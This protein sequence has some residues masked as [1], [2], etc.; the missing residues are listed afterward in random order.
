MA[1]QR[2]LKK[3][4]ISIVAL[5][6]LVLAL[7]PPGGVA[8]ANHPLLA[9]LDVE[10]ELDSNTTLA[11]NNSHTVTATLRTPEL[12]PSPSC[13]GDPMNA[14]SGGGSGPVTIRFEILG[15]NDPLN[16]GDTPTTP[17][18]TCVIPDG[19]ASCQADYVGTLEGTDVI[20]GWI[21]HDGD[22]NT[23]EAD[24]TEE[25]EEDDEP[26]DDDEPDGTDVVEKIWKTILDCS[27]ETDVN[28]RRAAHTITC[29]VT[30]G[31]G[32][33][34][35]GVQVDAEATGASD[36]DGTGSRTSPDF[37][38]T[39]GGDGTCAFTHGPGGTGT[40]FGFGLTTYRAWIDQDGI[41]S[42]SEAD[43]TE[44]RDENAAPGTIAEP[45]QT[46]VV[47]KTWQSNVDCEP[48]TEENDAG[49][50][51][52]ITCTVSN[53][54]N[55][56]IGNEKI[57]VEATGANDPDDSNSPTTYD[58][59]CTTNVS[60]TCSFTHG[61]GGS[62]S[63]NSSGVTTYRAWVDID[64]DNTTFD[65]DATEGR[66]EIT[67]P[68]GRPEPDD[69]DVVEK[70]WASVPADGLDA[71]P[72]SARNL[73]ATDHT[74]TA[75]LYDL[76]GN[77]F[78]LDTTVKFEFFAGSVSDTDGNTPESPDKTCT[79]DSIFS[80]AV[81]YSQNVGAGTDLVCVWTNEDPAMLGDNSNG[82][83]NGEGL[84]DLDDDAGNPDAPES[85][86]ADAIDVVEKVWDS[87]NLNCF[88]EEKSGRLGRGHA[89]SCQVTS[90]GPASPGNSRVDV[91]ATGV[92]D[93]TTQTPPRA[94]TSR[95]GRVRWASAI[96]NTGPQRNPERPLTGDGS[97]TTTSTARPNPTWTRVAT[98]T[99]LRERSWKPTRPM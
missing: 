43:G 22:A 6:S 61:P 1:G 42:T 20:R 64:L 73:R 70:T 96:S 74:I 31:L 88:P 89:F 35:A 91:E 48:E 52:T 90:D 72:E 66:D 27:P 93:P 51:H 81:T 16:D 18:E 30:D 10:P 87:F 56:T 3:N 97:T 19:E 32:G 34:V 39:T 47:E 80:C 94:R 23:S 2:R 65:A 15:P 36:P 8:H 83:C 58:F 68:G 29:S 77:E 79:T 17:D 37:S 82:T 55:P 9:C 57:A 11:P 54:L 92:N 4:A 98:R 46:D 75:Y 41:N 67:A 38:C 50:S 86:P 13:S 5:L 25:R 21:D 44:G 49:T 84:T 26:G 85:P 99:R 40:T 95:A 45:D 76:L 69:T 14:G 63:T 28:V 12:V 78:E 7:G 53:S 33:P 60:G 62:G 71:E 24:P 59:T